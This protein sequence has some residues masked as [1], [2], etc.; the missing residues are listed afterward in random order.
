MIYDNLKYILNKFGRNV[1][2]IDPTDKIEVKKISAFI[3]PLR[4]KDKNYIG[5]RYLDA[6]IIDGS[7]FL[8]IGPSDLRLDLYPLNSIIET[9]EESYVV[10]RAQKVC[11]KDDIVYIWAILQLY[12]EEV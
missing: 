11:F 6:G 5:S 1:K 9:N 3:Q 7:N 8:Y 12:V 4:Y 2:V 10:K